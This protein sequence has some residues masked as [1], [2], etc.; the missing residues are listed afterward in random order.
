MLGTMRTLWEQLLTFITHDPFVELAAIVCIALVIAGVLHALKQPVMIGYI[1][2]GVLVSPTLLN[3]MQHVEY[4]ETFAHI[5]IALLLFLVGLWLNPR[6]IKEVGKVAVV[7]GVGQV[8]FTTWIGA[9][10]TYGLGFDLLTSL[11]VGIALA[12]SSTIIIVKLLSDNKALDTLYG[13]IAIGL[14]I[15]QDIIAM[16]LLMT[17][18][19]LP[20]GD[21]VV[22]SRRA[23][24][25]TVLLKI[26]ITIVVVWAAIKRVLPRIAKYFAG[27]PELMLLFSLAVCFLFT[28]SSELLWFGMEVW[29]LIAW[30]SLAALPYRFEIMSKMKPLRDFF[31]ILFFVFLWSQ[32]QFSNIAE[33]IWPILILS[34]FVLLGNPFI[35]MTLMGLMGYQRNIGLMVWF[36]VAQ[37]SEFSFILMAI[38]RSMG[39]IQ[40]ANVVSMVT[41]IGLITITWSSY[42]FAYASAIYH[43]IKRY[44]R[45][46]ERISLSKRQHSPQHSEQISVETLVLWNH[47]TGES[48]V[49]T[50]RKKET[51][52]L[53]VDYNPHI[54]A[55]LEQQ[56]IPCIYGDASNIEFYEHIDLWALRMT[57]STIPD[58]HT[59]MTVLQLMKWKYPEMVV[60][61]SAKDLQEAEMLYA[62]GADYVLISQVIGG[63]YAAMLIENFDNN[64]EHYLALKEYHLFQIEERKA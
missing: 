13:K 54:I 58:Y 21:V 60:I 38:G 29:A 49:K 22:T 43:R 45:I 27:S 24:A 64:V 37:I 19:S 4:V 62:R 9:L 42:Y 51:S 57:I 8:V 50:L 55:K 28:V 30:L 48:I 34:F 12:F 47:R 18:A 52:F 46:F 44:L 2:T 11:Y 16:I 7:I 40:N 14:L 25:G 39:L 17:L 41:L 32:L 15:V 33:Y 26:L 63:Q 5:W 20:V 35:V 10:I 61:C 56:W 31:I 59:N 23:F 3:M 36:T 1:L 53:I 6:T